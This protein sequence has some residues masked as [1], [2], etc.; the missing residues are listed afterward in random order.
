MQV[1]HIDN[2]RTIQY[3][4]SGVTYIYIL[5]TYVLFNNINRILRS[6]IF[7]HALLINPEENASRKYGKRTN[8]IIRCEFPEEESDTKLNPGQTADDEVGV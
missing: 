8:K 6:Y 3:A 5:Y 2:Q 1:N 7:Q 4:M